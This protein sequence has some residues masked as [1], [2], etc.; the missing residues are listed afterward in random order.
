[1]KNVAKSSPATP[2]DPHE[3]DKLID[4]AAKA[5]G[6]E[7]GF[8][9]RGCDL[10]QERW[11]AGSLRSPEQRRAGPQQQDTRILVYRRSYGQGKRPKLCPGNTSS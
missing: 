11:W 6:Y 2:I 5:A 1:M 3:L 9:V 10:N 8:G 4:A 7:H